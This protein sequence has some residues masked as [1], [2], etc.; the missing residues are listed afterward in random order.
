M[1]S[2]TQPFVPASAMVVVA[3]PDDAEFMVAGTVAMWATAGCEV[4]Y[5]IITKGD[6][7]S[8]DPAMTPSLLAEIREA[9]QRAAGAILGVKQYE[10]MGYPDAYL[11]HTLDLRRDVTRLI[12]KYRPE[13]VI[14]FDP[15]SRFLG[16]F[17]PNHPDHRVAGDVAVDAVFPTARDRLTFPE[18][19]AEG[20]EPHKVSEVY[21][22]AS[23]EKC[24]HFVDIGAHLE[25]KFAALGAHAS[26]MGDWDFRA[27]L[28]RWAR[29]VATDARRRNFP[30][31]DDWD[32]AESFK[33]VHTY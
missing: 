2:D 19:L 17:Y 12:R 13:V 10:F 15:T 20:L 27:M 33:Y 16:D 8:D 21:I 4:T 9:E 6:K 5:V 31:A 1:P 14:T 30:G 18:L 26:Q 7:G 22:M 24:D 25:T 23:Q 29:D 3:H 11:Q 28:T 32:F